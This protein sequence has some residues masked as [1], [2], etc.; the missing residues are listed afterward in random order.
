MI[1]VDEIRAQELL[2]SVFGAE[3]ARSATNV[4]V[5][6]A[7]LAAHRQQAED[8]MRERCAKVAEREIGQSGDGGGGE[9]DSAYDDACTAIAIA[10]RTTQ[11][12]PVE[13]KG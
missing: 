8:A 9:W 1:E 6:A 12:R 2:S 13:Q 3:Y 11:T 4:E 7:F 10:I 5:V